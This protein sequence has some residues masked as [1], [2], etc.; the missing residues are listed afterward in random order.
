MVLQIDNIVVRTDQLITAVLFPRQLVFAHRQALA[1]QLRGE[2]EG[3]MALHLAAVVLFQ[4]LTQ[5][6]VHAPGR[7]VPAV[8]AHLQD[9]MEEQPHATLTRFQGR[10]SLTCALAYDCLGS[11][12]IT[13]FVNI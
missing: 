12:F 5:T 7:M 10:W 8:L 2:E 1:E 9:M 4:T 13:G 6:M 3:A 11:V